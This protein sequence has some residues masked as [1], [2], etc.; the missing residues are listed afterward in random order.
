MS[1]AGFADGFC[2]SIGLPLA[3]ARDQVF[4]ERAAGVVRVVEGDLEEDD[5]DG[6]RVRFCPACFLRLKPGILSSLG[7]TFAR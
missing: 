4:V 7:C 6:R 2:L 5:K 3:R 1:T